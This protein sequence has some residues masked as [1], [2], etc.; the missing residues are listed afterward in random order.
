MSDILNQCPKAVKLVPY[1]SKYG[2]GQQIEDRPL[3]MSSLQ[4]PRLYIKMPLDRNLL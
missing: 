1:I 4:S 3:K 2:L